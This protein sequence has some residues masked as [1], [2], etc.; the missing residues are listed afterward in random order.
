MISIKGIFKKP[1][2][3]RQVDTMYK[4]F[5]SDLDMGH[6]SYEPKINV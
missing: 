2:K 5:S 6:Q 4:D 3:E 1:N